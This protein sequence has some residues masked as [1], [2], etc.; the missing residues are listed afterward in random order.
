M[1]KRLLFLALLGVVSCSVFAG[2]E[3]TEKKKSWFKQA[4]K[5]VRGVKDSVQSKLAPEDIFA[6]NSKGETSLCEAARRGNADRVRYLL[7]QWDA[8]QVIDVADEKGRTPLCYAVRWNSNIKIVKILL[9]HGANINVQLDNGSTVL[10]EALRH[11][12]NLSVVRLL[13]ESDPTLIS[14][15]DQIG[16][17]PL[18]CAVGSSKA[19][20]VQ[21]L[22]E[23]G[24]RDHLDIA[25]GGDYTSEL[26]LY[27]VVERAL[28]SRSDTVEVI[29]IMTLLFDAGCARHIHAPTGIESW[30]KED[31]PFNKAI[32]VGGAVFQFMVDYVRENRIGIPAELAVNYASKA[33]YCDD[34]KA[35]RTRAL[36]DSGL[37][38]ISKARDDRGQTVLLHFLRFKCSS[39]NTS[40]DYIDD[41]IARVEFVIERAGVSHLF[42]PSENGTLPLHAAVETCSIKLVKTLLD[43]GADKCLET[44][45]EW[46]ESGVLSCAINYYDYTDDEAR[47]QRMR[48]M[49]EFLLQSGCTTVGGSAF[50]TIV[51]HEELSDILFKYISKFSVIPEKEMIKKVKS[52]LR[53]DRFEL[54]ERML[55]FVDV[56]AKDECKST[57]LGHF[58]DRHQLCRSGLLKDEEAN[59]KRIVFLLNH[60]ADANI[61]DGNGYRTNYRGEKESTHS[62]WYQVCREGLEFF[63][64]F[65]ERSRVG[66]T[67]TVGE[68]TILH[69]IA[70]DKDIVTNRDISDDVLAYA[71]KNGGQKFIEHRGIRGTTALEDALVEPLY[72]DSKTSRVKMLLENGANP[73]SKSRLGAP[74]LFECFSEFEGGKSCFELLV[75]HGAHIFAVTS[76]GH[77]VFHYSKSYVGPLRFMSA[78]VWPGNIERFQ[79]YKAG[80]IDFEQLRQY[81]VSPETATPDMFI[82]STVE[83]MCLHQLKRFR[84]MFSDS[85]ITRLNF[86]QVKDEQGRNTLDVA[87]Q[88]GYARVVEYVEKNFAAPKQDRW[89]R[90][91][92]NKRSWDSWNDDRW[93]D[94]SWGGSSGSSWMPEMEMPKAVRKYETK[95]LS[96]FHPEYICNADWDPTYEPHAREVL[97]VPDNADKSTIKMVYRYMSLKYHPDKNPHRRDEATEASKKINQAYETLN[98]RS[99][100]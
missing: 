89:H 49:F 54:A 71:L 56:N 85:V 37:I 82:D 14:I 8:A 100:L 19:D 23:H 87:K 72:D 68:D 25:Y 10:H 92:W 96:G 36:L 50:S 12:C 94:N 31:T 24:A 39:Y 57:L 52:A 58:V 66:F 63:H 51:K 5:K 83:Q 11:D 4:W 21:F 78:F 79:E 40:V 55:G 74:L 27:I 3:G 62:V 99:R 84:K 64:W 93:N 88:H 46:D 76:D 32:Q 22:L 69:E 65:F 73:N 6:Q 30:N 26:A 53:G 80:K 91:D 17:L 13:I 29:K 77:T 70:G 41:L 97:A 45:R 75:K 9:K 95:H 38:D 15:P 34:R 43:H 44:T 16:R 90:G 1:K 2:D 81:L 60:G 33:L 47:K 42:I 35:I 98:R 18:H 59:K 28:Y 61:K 20:V 67:C 48:D 86:S 7:E